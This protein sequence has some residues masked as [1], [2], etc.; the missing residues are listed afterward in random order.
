MVLFYLLAVPVIYFM[1]YKNF[2][3]NVRPISEVT[4]PLLLP[5]SFISM[6]GLLVSCGKCPLDETLWPLYYC[7]MFSWAR[8]MIL[9]QV[10]YV[11]KQKFN[12]FNLGTLSFLVPSFIFFF[13]DINPK[14]YFSCVAVLTGLVF[15]EF[16]VS[17]IN[18]SARMLSINV[19]SIKKRR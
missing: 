9:I 13:I 10:C 12:P 7:L 1:V 15:L 3:E 16:V 19:F 4:Q 14:I 17:V 2:S 8:N 5:F 11:A 18:Q 6:L